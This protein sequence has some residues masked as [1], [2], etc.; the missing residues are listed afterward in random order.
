MLEEKEY[1]WKEFSETIR[2]ILDHDNTS[3][4]ILELA[5]RGKYRLPISL[6]IL[7]DANG[8][9]VNDAKSGL[10]GMV[11]QNPLTAIR[12]S[13]DRLQEHYDYLVGQTG[14]K[15]KQNVVLGSII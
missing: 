4:K 3:S 11:L 10:A 15:F 9:Q 14:Q 1:L 7:R 12:I 13:E 6:D 2:Q 8:K 5:G